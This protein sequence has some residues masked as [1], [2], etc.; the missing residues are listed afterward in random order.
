MFF[1]QRTAK[2]KQPISSVSFMT[3]Q[4][5]HPQEPSIR[6]SLCII[7]EYQALGMTMTSKIP[8]STFLLCHDSGNSNFLQRNFILQVQNFSNTAEPAYS[9]NIYGRFLAIVELSLVPFFFYLSI[10][11]IIDFSFSRQN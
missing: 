3:N 4:M 11:V 8:P 6:R 1:N 5:A 10:P 9:Y 7:P 2:I